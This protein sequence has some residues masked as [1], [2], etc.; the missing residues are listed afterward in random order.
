MTN[1]FTIAIVIL[2]LLGILCRPMREEK[3]RKNLC[4]CQ[5]KGWFVVLVSR[6]AVCPGEIKYRCRVQFVSVV[7]YGLIALDSPIV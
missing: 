3:H 2:F 6:L 1:K 7:N 5:A 4:A